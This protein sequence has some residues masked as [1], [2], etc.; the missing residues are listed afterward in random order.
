ME[1]GRECAIS[2]ATGKLTRTGEQNGESETNWASS[3]YQH[4]SFSSSSSSGSLLWTASILIAF[5][6]HLA[7]DSKATNLCNCRCC[8]MRR[9]GSLQGNINPCNLKPIS[10]LPRDHI[11]VETSAWVRFFLPANRHD[12]HNGQ[13]KLFQMH[14]T[15]RGGLGLGFQN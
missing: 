8:K 7:T 12:R 5:E 10:L 3:H 1:R 15:G 6:E 13:E 2:A 4:P 11:L 9:H 14:S